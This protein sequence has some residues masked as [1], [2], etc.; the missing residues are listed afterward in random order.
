MENLFKKVFFVYLMLY[1]LIPTGLGNKNISD[2]LMAI[3]VFVYIIKS[4]YKKE[5]RTNLKLKLKD[6]IKDF[7]FITMVL[8][9]ICMIIPIL[10]A[11]HKGIV[12][13]ESFRFVTYIF[14]YV[15]IKY[16]FNLTKNF[17]NYYLVFLLQSFVIFTYGIIQKITGIGVSV[18]TN[19]VY[20]MESTLGYPTAF[21]AYIVIM[22]F[23]LLIF[24]INTKH[25]KLKIFSGINILLGLISLVL[26]YSRNGW[27]A[28]IV[29]LVVLAI[30]YNYKFIFALIGGGVVALIVPFMRNRLMDLTSAAINGGRV[31]LW[32]A[33]L[34]MI[35]DKPFKGVG[36]GN[37]TYKYDEYCAKYPE[38]YEIGHEG[39]PTHNSYLKMWSELG[40][41]GMLIFFSSYVAMM[42]RLFDANKKYKN[43]YMGIT[44]GVIVSFFAFIFINFFDNMMFTPKVMTM[45]IVLVSVCIT[46]DAKEF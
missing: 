35:R 43:K 3:F 34:K 28:L 37:F 23:P 44:I 5:E 2:L 20:R 29:G 9:V 27:L 26:S 39:F 14:L 11:E 10:Y 25:K 15:A 40:T 13:S 42:F 1:P 33:A 45:F 22:I 21:A 36:T 17:S 12:V 31:K 18:E 46:L 24:F 30:I 7:V 32:K 4:L 19:G 16:E 41:I 38:L 8:G 6:L